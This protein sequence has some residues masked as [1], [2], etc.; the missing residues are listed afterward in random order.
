MKNENLVNDNN[1]EEN[2]GAAPRVYGWDDVITYDYPGECDDQ[3]DAQGEPPAATTAAPVG[4]LT[5]ETPDASEADYLEAVAQNLGEVEEDDRRDPEHEP[6]RLYPRTG[7]LYNRRRLPNE[8]AI[9]PGL[10]NLRRRR[11]GIYDR[12]RPL[13]RVKKLPEL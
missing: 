9:L 5:D 4:T 1:Q 8:G 10:P 11:K 7:L 3:G 12:R 6:A 2:T 13:F